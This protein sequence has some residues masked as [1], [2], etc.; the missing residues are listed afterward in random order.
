M[1]CKFSN[2]PCWTKRWTLCWTFFN[3]MNGSI[4]P[5]IIAWSVGKKL[6]SQDF[7]PWRKIPASV[8]GSIKL[9]KQRHPVSE[10]S[11]RGGRRQKTTP[12]NTTPA[13]P[14]NISSKST[15]SVQSSTYSQT[16]LIGLF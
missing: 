6:Q 10:S 12:R 1:T 13:R 5:F 14:N 7:T 3:R 16:P 2:G 11:G 9:R 8:L 4:I 15:P